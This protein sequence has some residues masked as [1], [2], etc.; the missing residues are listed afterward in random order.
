MKYKPGLRLTLR[1]AAKTA[2]IPFAL[3]LISLVAAKGA[4]IQTLIETGDSGP[5]NGHTIL[6]FGLPALNVAAQVPY[7]ATLAG[8]SPTDDG[9]DYSLVTPAGGTQVVRAF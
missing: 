9:I 2:I 8:V 3:G 4:G 5:S 6:R 7:Y 1:D